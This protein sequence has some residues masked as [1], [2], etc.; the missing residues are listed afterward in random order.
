MPQIT[1]FLLGILLFAGCEAAAPRQPGDGTG[2][3]RQG[4]M[5]TDR[6]A[7]APATADSDGENSWKG[8]DCNRRIP[9]VTIGTILESFLPR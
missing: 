9:L 8:I 1:A 6:P 3:Q 4:R 5:Q 7:D 2:P